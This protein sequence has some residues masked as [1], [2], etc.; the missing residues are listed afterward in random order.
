LCYRFQD[1]HAALITIFVRHAGTVS[2]VRRDEFSKRCNHK[3]DATIHYR[4]AGKNVWAITSGGRRTGKIVKRRGTFKA[5]M[6]LDVL[7]NDLVNGGRT[8]RDVM[9]G[10]SA[11]VA[12]LNGKAA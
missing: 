6:L 8:P 12:H 5:M 2:K 4:P 7:C 3:M 9:N 1:E 10:V 11:F